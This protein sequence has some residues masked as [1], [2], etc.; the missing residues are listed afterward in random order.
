MPKNAVSKSKTPYKVFEKAVIESATNAMTDY[1][2]LLEKPEQAE[3]HSDKDNSAEA[4][5]NSE[6]IDRWYRS[7]MSFLASS[8]FA[9]RQRLQDATFTDARKQSVEECLESLAATSDISKQTGLI[10]SLLVSSM[11]AN[12]EKYDEDAV[13]YGRLLDVLRE[14]LG[15]DKTTA[16]DW[17]SEL[18]V[19][20]P[21]STP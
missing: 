5:S 19:Q 7:G 2:A 11:E 13:H 14:A 16:V 6:L 9:V 18:R 17:R 4:K 3:G 20:V 12:V 15:I 8:V 10:K 21:P 1:L